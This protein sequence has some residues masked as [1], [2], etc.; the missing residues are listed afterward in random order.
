MVAE[1]ILTPKDF[2]LEQEIANIELMKI[3]FGE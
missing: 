3:R 2:S 1:K